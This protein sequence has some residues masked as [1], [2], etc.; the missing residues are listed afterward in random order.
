MKRYL[1]IITTILILIPY[2]VNALSGSISISCDSTTLTINSTTTCVVNGYSNEEVSAITAKYNTS[3]EISIINVS[4][5]N[6]WQGNG[7]GGSFDLYTD[8]NKVGNLPIGTFT[9]KASAN[10]GSGTITFYSVNFSDASYNSNVI[11]GISITINTKAQETP[12]PQP[13]I[14]NSNQPTPDVPSE[15]DNVVSDNNHTSNNIDT[16]NNDATLKSLTISS[17]NINFSSDIK[18]YNLEVSNE[19]DKVTIDAIA[20]NDK[21][22]VFIPED[23][24]LRLGNNSFEIKVIAEDNTESIYKINI[25]RLDKVLSSNS[26]LKTLK[27]KGYNIKFNK[28]TYI[29]NLGDIKESSL[30]IDFAKEDTKSKVKIYGNENIRKN[31]V[32]LIKVTAEDKTTTEYIIYANNVNNNVKLSFII[33][34]VLFGISLVG[35]ILLVLY[36]YKKRK[37]V[38]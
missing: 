11:S 28:D 34:I 7:S 37:L 32:I 16:K 3:G 25:T 15:N 6:V 20:N 24:S 38:K 35:N 26:K 22:K 31:D 18:E 19:V 4:S 5:S 29:Y 9:I 1:F 36:I 8:E 10:V 23:L 27:I 12:T 2:K 17:A 13:T 33:P 14:P 21:A 30:N